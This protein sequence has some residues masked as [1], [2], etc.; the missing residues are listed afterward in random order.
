MP[1]DTIIRKLWFVLVM[2][3]ALGVSMSQAQSFS[4]DWYS[5]DGGGGTSTGGVYAVTGTIGQPD[6]GSLMGGEYALE[7]GFWGILAVPTAAG[8]TLLVVPAGLGFATI[9]WNPDSPG[10]VLQMN[11]TVDNPAGWSDAPS[12]SANPAT[13]PAATGNRFF[14]VRKP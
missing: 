5:M 9:S 12:G 10:F 3:S 4:I 1:G 13:V 7:G 11:S 2:A 14:R 8:P 6:A